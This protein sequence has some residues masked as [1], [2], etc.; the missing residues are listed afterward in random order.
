MGRLAAA[1]Y[2]IP[3]QTS[4]GTLYVPPVVENIARL[5]AAGYLQIQE[6]GEVA[7]GDTKDGKVKIKQANDMLTAIQKQE[8]V[9]F[10]VTGH[11]LTR[12]LQVS[13]WPDNTTAIIG[14]DGIHGEPFHVTMSKRF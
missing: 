14:T 8:L 6:Y 10:D 7:E 5:L 9:L 1:G 2:V 11:P 12:S 3:L 4:N 13:G